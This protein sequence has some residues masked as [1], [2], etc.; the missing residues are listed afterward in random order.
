M[1]TVARTLLA[2]A[3]L[4]WTASF[5]AAQRHGGLVDQWF[6]RQQQP[7]QDNGLRQVDYVASAAAYNDGML[8]A[9]AGSYGMSDGQGGYCGDGCNGC[10]DGSC[11]CGSACGCDNGYGDCYG[12]CYGDP[13]NN[14]GDCYSC[15]PYSVMPPPQPHLGMC[16][17][18]AQVIAMRTHISENAVGKLSEQYEFSWRGIVGYEA[19]NGVGARGRYWQYGRTTPIL[20]GIGDNLRLD[21]DVIDA[22]VTR[23]FRTRGADLIVSGGFRWA[24]MST[25]LDDEVV[26]AEMPGITLALDARGVICRH[27]RSEWAAVCGGRWSLLGG[28][29]EGDDGG[30]IAPTRD[31]NIAVYEYYG[32]AEYV[33][34]HRSCSCF[35]RLVFE[36]QHW[37]SDAMAQTAGADSIGFFGPAVHAGVTY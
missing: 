2:V 15:Q 12:N 5:A 4:A 18:D 29:W 36:V 11:G 6:S 23:R 17:A 16:Y 27:H 25:E 35:A 26:D 24:T 8:G 31:D 30:L 21:F 10:N 32:G 1:N 9:E 14:Y 13:C 20:S 37:H 22:E 28:D 34:H 33:R 3:A 19:A 7:T